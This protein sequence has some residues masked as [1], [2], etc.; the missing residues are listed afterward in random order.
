MEISETTSGKLTKKVISEPTFTVFPKPV[1]QEYIEVEP[2]VRLHVTDAGEGRP[3]VLIPGWPLSDEM[4]MKPQ[5]AYISKQPEEL[6]LLIVI[7]SSTMSLVLIFARKV[8]K[9]AFVFIIRSGS[10]INFVTNRGNCI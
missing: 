6:E 3:I 5:A 2:N 9:Q 4:Y 10:K 7:L 1:R 8:T